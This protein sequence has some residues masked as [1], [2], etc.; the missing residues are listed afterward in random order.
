MAP[1]AGGPPSARDAAATRRRILDAA[2]AEFSALGLSGART[3]GI[4]DG[5]GANQRMIYAYF[6]N[7]DGLFDAVLEHNILL[8]Q[9]A[10]PF[11]PA[12]L[13]G[14]AGRVF[15]F[16]RANPHLVRLELWQ[17]LQRTEPMRSSPLIRSAIEHKV[18][19]LEQAQA[20]GLVSSVLPAAQLLDHILTLA[21]GHPM[22]AG[23]AGSWTDGR[24]DA[25]AAAVAVLTGQPAGGP[26]GSDLIPRA[27]AS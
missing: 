21:H 20:D 17:T 5:A 23:D 19:A 8:V 10:V 1:D 14:Y 7:K 18:A 15:D 9:T 24:R 11:D 4:A 26:H 25:L 6:G 22:D 13:P 27:G 16:Y 2:T 3:A 12:D